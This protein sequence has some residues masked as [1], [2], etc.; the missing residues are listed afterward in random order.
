[1]SSTSS[2]TDSSSGLAPPSSPD[3]S[4]PLAREAQRVCPGAPKARR[5]R[6]HSEERSPL[7]RRRL[8]FSPERETTKQD[9]RRRFGLLATSRTSNQMQSVHA[10][11]VICDLL[12]DDCSTPALAQIQVGMQMLAWS[13]CTEPTAQ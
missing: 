1:M 12:V 11:S 13:D 5:T 8:E 4:F 9:L 7:K 2:A 6:S 10:L 3:H